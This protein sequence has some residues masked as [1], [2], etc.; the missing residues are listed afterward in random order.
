MKRVVFVAANPIDPDPRA[1]KQIITL[2]NNG[3]DVFAL[4]W[5]RSTNKNVR[6]SIDNIVVYRKGIKS[7]F[8]SGVKNLIP[9][10]KWQFIVLF[11]LIR[12]KKM[13]DI[14]HA[15]NFDTVLPSIIVK[16][17]F[18]KKVI[19]DIYDFYV[20]SFLVPTKLI[21]IIKWLDFWAIKNAD[22]IILPIEYRK[23]QIA[24]S[25]YKKIE[26]IH[27]TPFN[28][29]VFSHRVEEKS[30]LIITYVGILSEDRFL[31]EMVRIVK[32]NQNF[33]LHLA[34]FGIEEKA[35]IKEIDN[36]SN[37]YFYGKV[38][39]IR[40]LELSAKA[41]VLFCIY[42]PSIPNHKYS[43]PNKMYEAMMLGKPII[44][45]KGT[46][47]DKIVENE[48]IGLVIN[49]FDSIDVEKALIYLDNNKEER[50]SMAINSKRAYLERYSWNVME[51]RLLQLYSDL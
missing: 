2:K 34:G 49:Y 1:E 17:L 3:F 23:E 15:A 47:V 35:I 9:L 14:I 30:S 4:G 43:A 7:Q 21:R 46:G 16:F 24:G 20:E 51:K 50:K 33:V 36:A 19:Y 42:N 45:A 27:N 13:Y 32:K 26:F 25:K 22:A 31:K 29:D 10:I 48:E 12:N 38:D 5:D 41:D 37:I 28:I 18:G 11:F 6:G 8:G 40:S 44:V 39:Y